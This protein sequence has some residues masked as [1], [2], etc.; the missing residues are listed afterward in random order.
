MSTIA[1]IATA[2]G[3][4]IGIIRVSGPDAIS[5]VDSVFSKDIH[6]AKGY[7][8]HYGEITS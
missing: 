1:A 8:L 3:G 2:P 5:I 7:T 6:D 4:A